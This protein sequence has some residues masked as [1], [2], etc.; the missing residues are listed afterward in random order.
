MLDVFGQ[1]PL[2][3]AHPFWDEPSIIVT[4][5]IVAQPVAEVA[6]SRVAET[7]R[8]LKCG[9]IPAAKVDPAKGYDG[10]PHPAAGRHRG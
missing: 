4:P 3:D 1:E 8:A 6:L 9:D 10:D 7:L 2:P 5:H